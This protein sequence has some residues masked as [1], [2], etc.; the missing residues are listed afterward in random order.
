MPLPLEIFQY[1]HNRR[2]GLHLIWGDAKSEVAPL[3]GWS[4]ESLDDAITHLREG[5]F[6]PSVSFGL[7]SLFLQKKFPKVRLRVG[8]CALNKMQEGCKAL[9]LKIGHLT[10]EEAII[11]IRKYVGKIPLRLDINRKYSLEKA[12]M[13]LGAFP[14]GA[15]QFVEEPLEYPEQILTLKKCCPHPYALDESL[16]D[17]PLSF[18]LQT[19]DHFIIKPTL[20]GG[21]GLCCFLRDEGKKRG[22][23]SHLST[24]YESSVGLEA[25]KHMAITCGFPT[26]AMGLDAISYQF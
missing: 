24:S 11:L 22:I 5:T 10:A 19:A 18:C 9:K 20:Q 13:V 23:I 3:P 17:R 14:E 15:F 2:K 25:I 8:I 4:R 12:K 7:E 6:A 16:R 26:E 1:Q 21:V